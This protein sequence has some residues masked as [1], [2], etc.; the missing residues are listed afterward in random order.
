MPV[1]T[2]VQDPVQKTKEMHGHALHIFMQQGKQPYPNRQGPQ[3]LGGLKQSDATKAEM[4][5]DQVLFSIHEGRNVITI[6]YACLTRRLP[7][8]ACNMRL[9][10]R[11]G[12][13]EEYKYR[14][15]IA[16]SEPD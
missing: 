6:L 12:R 10:V 8:N 16:G 2:Q 11:S 1:W 7:A 4:L 14:A 13:Q 9:R 3:P 15:F 5:S